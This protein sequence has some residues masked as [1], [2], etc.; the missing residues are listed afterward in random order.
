MKSENLSCHSNESTWA[1]GIKNTTYVEPNVVNNSAKFQLHPPYGV[2]D[3]FLI[4]FRKF[5]LSF[6]MATNQ[7]QRFGQKYVS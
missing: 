2:W 7:I 3:D 5:S 4:F 1:T 6:A